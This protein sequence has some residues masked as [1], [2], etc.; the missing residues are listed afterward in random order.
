ML[1]NLEIAFWKAAIPLMRESPFVQTTLRR[2]LPLVQ[3]KETMRILAQMIT[4]VSAG[5]VLGFGIG[6]AKLVLAVR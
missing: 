4:L 6:L 5:L 1:V 3:S 2:I